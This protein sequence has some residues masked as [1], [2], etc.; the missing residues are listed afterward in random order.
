MVALVYLDLE[1]V[2]DLDLV[3]DLD[4]DLVLDLDLDL[5]IE[6]VRDREYDLWNQ[7]ISKRLIGKPSFLPTLE[8]FLE[9]SIILLTLI[10]TVYL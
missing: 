10:A 6:R 3:L 7:E 2:W 4:L 5:D 9:S 1:R 8:S